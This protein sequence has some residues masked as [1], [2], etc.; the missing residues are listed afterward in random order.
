MTVSFT[1]G[2]GVGT[3]VTIDIPITDDDIL[4]EKLKSFFGSLVLQPTPLN[5]MVE[6][7]MTEVVIVDD[8]SEGKMLSSFLPLPPHL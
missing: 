3:E 4:E 5:V 7:S 2:Q 8:D 6:P 1:S